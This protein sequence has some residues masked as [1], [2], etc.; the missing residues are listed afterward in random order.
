[1]AEAYLGEI[2]AVAFDYA[3][4]E[5]MMC[6]GQLISISDNQTLFALLSN[7]F[8][9]DG[10]TTF[11]LPDLRARTIIG[12]GEVRGLTST[13]LA[14]SGGQNTIRISE[15]QM[16]LHTHGATFEGLDEHG[17]KYVPTTTPSSLSAK[18]TVNAHDGKGDKDNAKGNYWATG[19]ENKKKGKTNV[20]DGYSDSSDVQMASDAVQID[21]SGSAGGVNSMTDANV[22]IE[23]SGEGNPIDIRTPFLSL[24][25]IICV[26]GLFPPRR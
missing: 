23:N 13:E 3:P 11:A 5:W 24:H 19:E 26:M 10:K 16:P 2:K 8:G 17:K 4:R 12:A 6:H 18:V 22:T 21:I 9:G 15:S 25:Y 1:M 20:T 14:E 7:R